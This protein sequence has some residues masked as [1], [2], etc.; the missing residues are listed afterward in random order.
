MPNV[1]KPSVFRSLRHMALGSQATNLSD[2]ELLEGFLDRRDESFFEAL[3]LRHGPMVLGA[4]RRVLRNEADAH[5]AFQA[6]FLV[7]LRKAATIVPRTMVGNWLYGVAH[8]TAL[9]AQTMN[10]QRRAKEHQAGAKHVSAPPTALQ[11]RLELLDE[12]LGRLPVKYRSA[13]VQCDLEG[14]TIKEAAIHLQCPSGTVASRLASGR[15]LLAKRLARYGLCLTAAAI[16]GGLA[17]AAIPAVVPKP[18]LASTTKAAAMIAAGQEAASVLSAKVV[19]LSERVVKAMLIAKLK[20]LITALLGL[21]VL[22]GVG[23]PWG[24]QALSAGQQEDRRGPAPIVTQKKEEPRSDRELIQGTWVIVAGEQNGKKFPEEKLEGKIVFTKDKF[25]LH[26]ASG[27]VREGTYTIDPEK[28]PKELD[29]TFG[30]TTIMG[31]YE[32][33]GTTLKIVGME[34]GRPLDLDSTNATL[35]TYERKK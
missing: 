19:L 21:A 15:A 10:R 23:M 20:T 27:E 33:K 17:Q 4:C 3:L 16:A 28:M 31:L 8:K 11:D 12:A 34:R 22:G 30:N 26:L 1:Q 25:S 7:F 2:G 29:M 9:K 14:K 18:L 13:I 24:Y 6:T 32:V 5:D 35:I